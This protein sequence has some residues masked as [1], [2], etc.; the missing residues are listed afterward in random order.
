MAAETGG[1][2]AAIA[3]ARNAAK[4]AYLDAGPKTPNPL[5]RKLRGWLGWPFKRVAMDVAADPQFYA[6]APAPSIP[7][8]PPP[9]PASAPSTMPPPLPIGDAAAAPQGRGRKIL[10]HLKVLVIAISVAIVVAGAAQLAME[11]LFS[12]R[13][14]LFPPK[15]QSQSPTATEPKTVP[16]NRTG[17]PMPAPEGT[18]PPATPAEPDTTNSISGASSFFDPATTIKLPDGASANGRPL[19]P[20][21]VPAPRDQTKLEPPAGISAALRTAALADDPAAEYELGARYAE[22]RGLA[23][24]LPDAVRWFERAADAGFAPAQFRLASLYEKGEGMK[25]DIQA[26][27]RFYLAAANKGHAKAMHNL[28][29]L[30]AEGID[31]KPDYKTAAEWFRKAAACGVTD[32]QYNLAILF[33]RGIGLPANLAESYRWFALAAANGDSDAAKKRD[34]VA[35]RLEPQALAAAKLAVQSFAAEREPDEAT[36][37]RTPPGG[38]DRVPPAPVKP[39]RQG[40]VSQ[41]P[42]A[43]PLASAAR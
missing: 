21:R 38:W 16:P 29:V 13:P 6:A 37:L 41:A 10:K 12:D 42:L 5:S 34:E 20:T 25:K 23:Q 43:Q 2:S 22:G 28:A 40:P 11:Y 4:A 9:L 35:A 3:A 27:R 30:Y 33:A 26:A 18:L 31:G 32:S 39:R 24:S 17:R 14:S 8:A 19:S 1:K 7:S 36:N 15:D